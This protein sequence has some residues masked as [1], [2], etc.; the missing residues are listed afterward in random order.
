MTTVPETRYAKSGDVH[1][2]YQVLGDGPIDL[3]FV[4]GFVSNVEVGWSLPGAAAF[5][6]RL[7]SFARVIFFDKRGTGLSDRVSTDRLPDLETRMD[8]VRAVMD[9]AGSERAVLLGISEGGAMSTLFAAM[10]PERTVAL[11]LM[12]TFARMLRAPG[13]PFG[14]SEE[15]Y[16]RRLDVLESDD[17]AP[18]VAL[19][20]LGRVGPEILEDDDAVRWYVSYLV[21]GASPAASRAIR[22][23]NREIDIRDVLPTIAV[24]SQ[25]LY[26]RDEYF[27]EA[28]RYMGERIPGARVVELPG[29]HHL[30]WEGDL[31][32]LLAEIAR[33]LAS[34]HEEGPTDRVL[35][36]LLFTDIVGS[37]VK[38]AELGDS[39]WHEL[40]ARHHALVRSRIARFR[41]Q[42]VASTGDG[43]FAVFDG[44]ARAVRC[45]VSLIAAVRELGLEIRAGV[46]T[47]EI[48]RQGEELRGIGVPIAA[49][50]MTEAGPGEVL[51]SSTV[52]AIAAGSG[53]AFA[54][55]GEHELAGIPG[56]WRLYAP[57]P[58]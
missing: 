20:W 27:G 13:Y 46:H 5:H 12:G 35:A 54:E 8:D 48:Q 17:W 42:E 23:M 34:V 9:A 36:T 53:I 57:S 22:L 30:P 44:P 28:T 56:R 39:R 3:V 6:R 2:A 21:S 52:K 58:A 25:V 38:A 7:A 26:R 29:N 4:P 10:H 19:E 40:L 18:K 16:Q 14:V 1:I 15:E 47:G 37:T 41:G 51:V 32:A 43:L 49:R 33:F 31:D 24:P 45:A 50:V 55:R 11:V